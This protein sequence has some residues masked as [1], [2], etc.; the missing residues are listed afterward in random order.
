MRP[1]NL[2]NVQI[3]RVLE[4]APQQAGIGAFALHVQFIEH[5][6][7][8]FAHHFI[9]PDA[10]AFGVIA[11]GQPTERGQQFQVIANLSFNAGPHDFNNHVTAVVERGGMHLRDR[12][13][14]HR[15]FIEMPE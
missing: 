4:V 6:A 7:L 8:E 10:F 2:R 1:V 14:S 11:P 15:R 3:I 5:H 13:R 12:G 9:G